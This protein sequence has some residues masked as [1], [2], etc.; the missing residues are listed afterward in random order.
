MNLRFVAYVLS[1]LCFCNVAALLIPLLVAVF[2]DTN[3]ILT[4]VWAEVPSA[5]LGCVLAY[6]GREQGKVRM[7][8]KDA[9][10]ITGGGWLLVCILGM[11]PYLFGMPELDP[12]TCLFESTSQWTTTGVTSLKGFSFLSP[13]F[14]TW[15]SVGHFLGATGVILAFTMLMPQMR[16]G[17]DFILASEMPGRALE[18]TMPQIKKSAFYIALIFIGINLCQVLLLLLGG[19][20]L[21]LAVNMAVSCA[22]TAGIS[23]FGDGI[24]QFPNTYFMIVCLFF[25]F[26]GGVNFNLWFKILHRD[27]QAV[28]RDAEWQYYVL[29]ILICTCL[30]A[31]GLW[32]GA[33]YDF[34]DCLQKGL[35]MSIS[36]LSTVGFAFDSISGWP[37]F[38]Q[39]VFVVMMFTGGCSS[40]CS[41][42][43][44]LIRC[45]IVL[46]AAWCEIRHFWHPNMTYAVQ[47]GGQPVKSE[48][49]RQMVRFFFFYI[50]VAVLLILLGSCTGLSL[51]EAVTMVTACMSTAG[52]ALGSIDQESTYATVGIMPRF[53]AVL[54]M[55]LGR[56]EFTTLVAM[57]HPDFWRQKKGW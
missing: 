29:W 46:K 19:S 30:L 50:F 40:S 24:M 11:F 32:H 35:M 27:W 4:F 37:D 3:H 52:C 12:V 54:A 41:G 21:G 26:L 18:R 2:K 15:R 36:Y 48:T 16:A 44:K 33:V 1:R 7:N 23:F 10:L 53:V 20:D 56:L 14:V 28:R 34:T 47:Y 31:L 17:T 39:V 6:W 25:M 9:V 51:R 8:V 43:L 5:F 22:S 38:C 42:G 45:V 57:L 49:V 13:A 55:I